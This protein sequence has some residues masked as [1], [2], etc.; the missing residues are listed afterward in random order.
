LAESS[1]NLASR[2]TL[3]ESSVVAEKNS[4][5]SSKRRSNFFNYESDE[6][7]SGDDIIPFDECEYEKIVHQKTYGSESTILS[8]HQNSGSSRN[9]SHDDDT[10]G[11]NTRTKFYKL[12]KSCFNFKSATLLTSLSH[13]YIENSSTASSHRNQS[14][15]ESFSRTMSV[16]NLSTLVKE[17]AEPT[18]SVNSADVI[19]KTSSTAESELNTSNGTHL[20]KSKRFSTNTLSKRHRRAIHNDLSYYYS[21][22]NVKY[23][24]IDDEDEMEEAAVG[25]SNMGHHS[26]STHNLNSQQQQQ[27]QQQQQSVS[28]SNSSLNSFNSS[29]SSNSTS[30]SNSYSLGERSSTKNSS[31]NFGSNDLSG[32]KHRAGSFSRLQKSFTMPSDFLSMSNE[33]T[34]FKSTPSSLV[35]KKQRAMSATSSLSSSCT[36][37][38]SISSSEDSSEPSSLLSNSYETEP[39]SFRFMNKPPGL[40]MNPAYKSLSDYCMSSSRRQFG[41]SSCYRKQSSRQNAPR[42]YHSRYSSNYLLAKSLSTTKKVCNGNEA[43]YDDNDKDENDETDEYNYD[44]EYYAQY[45]CQSYEMHANFA[46]FEE[47]IMD[48]SD[49]NKSSGNSEVYGPVV[50]KKSTAAAVLLPPTKTNIKLLNNTTSSAYDTCSNL[51]NEISSS[52]SCGSGSGHGSGGSSKN[53]DRLSS[54]NASGGDCSLNDFSSHKNACGVSNNDDSL[55]DSSSNLLY[56][57]QSEFV[58]DKKKAEVSS[59]SND[60]SATQAMAVVDEA[61]TTNTDVSD[62]HW[63]G[64][65]VISEKNLCQHSNFKI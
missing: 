47:K 16:E 5:S 11:C 26:L 8:H 13:S 42:H 35:V 3:I 24:N 10:P 56:E 63:D 29:S 20:K 31:S 25:G 21:L 55:N 65:T 48:L 27:Q 64:Y 43:D 39:R 60:L 52:L 58:G 41:M 30:E 7:Q 37:S 33:N 51:S 9:N 4:N 23:Y 15:L 40:Y 6:T 1:S 14:S 17:C 59:E 49:E 12:S 45:Q 53:S 18:F 50:T 22:T 54:G 62:P 28:L 46:E 34:A 44:N 19:T 32:S 38:S 36:L 2:L 61:S 57:I